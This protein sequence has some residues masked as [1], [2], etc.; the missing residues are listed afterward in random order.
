VSKNDGI[1]PDT[2]AAAS[3]LAE[4]ERHA[5]GLE[6]SP[7]W[8]A[9][10]QPIFWSEP[11]SQFVPAHW[12]Y[13][14][15]KAALAEA[16]GLV[17]LSLAERRILALRNPHPGNNFATTR[18]LSLA[19]Q[20]MLPGEIAGTHRH[21][22]HALRVM[23]DARGTYSIVD[24]VRM[25]MESGDVVLTPGGCWHGHGHDGDAPACWIDGLDIPL[26][27][28]LEPMYFEPYPG[29]HMPAVSRTETS[30][31]RFTA[32]D[33]ARGL[34]RA[35]PDGEGLAGRRF[36]L[37]APQ[38]PTMGLA[39][40]RLLCGERTRTQRSTA[41]RAF[42]AMAGTGTSRIGETTFQWNR[43]DTV[44]VPGWTWYEHNAGV[45][46]QLFELSD[47]PLMRACN[48]W[49]HEKR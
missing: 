5:A 14:K 27:H 29:R 4:L 21:A 23:L 28:L 12:D 46:A 35:V 26:T 40:M 33:I 42:V 17:D 11:R 10:D 32:S 34:D 18:T 38:V 13:A 25:P 41:S 44:A 8:I 31:F 43:G 37:T 3:A 45:D 39:V 49:R 48:Y 9:R 15:I 2:E 7:G 47:E 6:T 1:H 16:A 19:Y 30:P 36:E 22:P 24:G 20:Y